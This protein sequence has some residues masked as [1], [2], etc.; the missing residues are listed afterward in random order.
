MGLPF[1]VGGD[2]QVPP[3]DIQRSGILDLIDGI[4]MAAG[5]ATNIQSG[6]ELDYYIVSR[7]LAHGGATAEV[8][9]SGAFSPHVAVRLS[10]PL[11]RDEG[12]T[13][14]LRQPRTLPVN[15]IVGPLPPPR[16]SINWKDW[17]DGIQSRDQ[18]QISPEGANTKTHEWYSAAE[19]ELIQSHGFEVDVSPEYSGIGLAPV[20]VGA[21]RHGRY[22]ASP[23]EAGIIGQRLTWTAKG[24]WMLM[25]S[26]DAPVGS[27]YRY[28]ML[29]GLWPMAA[30]ARAYLREMSKGGIAKDG[31]RR[32]DL[33]NGLKLLARAGLHSHRTPPLLS[34]LAHQD[35]RRDYDKYSNAY[36][37]IVKAHLE[38]AAQRRKR[39]IRDARIWA[40]GAPDKVGHRVTKEP[41]FIATK[42]ASADKRHCGETTDQRAADVG[43]IEWSAI[44]HATEI[45]VGDDVVK[46]VAKI[47]DE[48][49]D[50][51]LQ[52][53]ALPPIDADAVRR[54]ARRFRGDTAVGTDGIRPRH[55]ARL[56]RGALD[57]LARLMEIFEQLQRWADIVRE[58]I[59]VGRSKKGGGARL[60]GL[61][62]TVYRVWAR[63]RF[64]HIRDT[65]ERR[66]E[67]SYLP[68][69]PGRGAINAVLDL[70]LADEA[71][72]ARG[73]ESATTSFDL[74]QYYEQVDIAEFARGARK[75]GL[76]LRTAT[77]LSHL[78]LGPRRIRVG[79][80]ISKVAYPRRSIL[81]GCTFAQLVIRLIIIHPV[82]RLMQR[83]NTTISNYGVRVKP[84]FYVDDGIVNT[85]GEANMVARWH[86]WI[87]R[88]AFNW[89]KHVQRKQIAHHKSTCIVSC[90][91]LRDKLAAEMDDVGIPITLSGEIL[92]V[93]YAAGG[94]L[95][96]RRTQYKRRQKARNSK[97]R[98]RWWKGLGGSARKVAK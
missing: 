35:D 34:R 7:V 3:A 71:A 44:W 38:I 15:R 74:R 18:Q 8:D 9:P 20:S 17:T 39:H 49:D 65:M 82:D 13:R 76:P 50:G 53:V 30:R 43:M 47:Y 63:L 83:I 86:G 25:S 80:A 23:D 54:A 85:S 55:L 77:L 89:V 59:E 88:L 6:N 36:G 60:V 87:T 29:Q 73:H 61:G 69:A 42:S 52:T 1:V 96:Q 48:M 40:R 45:D 57:G 24:I 2:W 97:K 84:V 10:L 28:K 26:M 62:T 81:A 94:E 12:T 93:D 64:D 70:A 21:S 16:Y 98:L 41:E 33:C 19:I 11:I 95:K 68:A 14:R 46:Q 31:Q 51:D 37:I 32:D 22:R 67:R 66:V 58:V 72:R 91:A 90:A 27:D 4:I 92:G 79:T 78:Y 56:A 75:F 5:R